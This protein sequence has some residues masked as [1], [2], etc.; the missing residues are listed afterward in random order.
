[1]KLKFTSLLV[2]AGLGACAFNSYADDLLQIYQ[3]AQQ[4][5]PVILQA[6]AERDAA[7]ERINQSQA[8]LLPQVSLSG[9]YTYSS[10]LGSYTPAKY[11]DASAGLTLTQSIFSRA[12][13]LNLGISEKNATQQEALYG[14]QQQDLMVRV[15]TA[16]FNVLRAIDDLSYVRANKTAVKRQL[17][18][19]Q[20]RYK[21]GLT[22]I[23]D[24]NEAQAEF[25]RTVAEE[26]QSENTLDNS[27]ESLR[28]LVGV[29]PRDLKLLNTKEF[30][31][32]P[33]THENKFWMDAAIDKNL[34]LNADRIAKQVAEQQIDVAKAGH[35]PTLSLEGGLS[36]QYKHYRND[37]I[38]ENASDEGH[39]DAASVGLQLSMPLYQGGEINSKV[40]EARYDYVAASQSLENT[41][42][43]VQTNLNSTYNNVRANLSSIKA[44]Q[45]TVKSSLSALKATEAG[46]KV[47]TRTIVDVQDATSNYYQAKEELA[48][49]RYDYIINMLTLK[50]LAGTLKESDLQGINNLLFTP[51]E[52]IPVQPAAPSLDN[53]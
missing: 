33:L 21:V 16:Y 3:L 19:T 1:M 20:Q 36:T 11:R 27:Y 50:Q 25:D 52:Q 43:T 40:R 28:K 24:V 13:W 46:F 4:K 38:A 2:A 45:Q 8:S 44:Y 17:D 6:K 39:G 10:T 26:I 12:N 15:A 23:T 29:M 53:K 14:Y 7:F 9:G 47:G 51:K 41:Y 22:P 31:P 34:Q 5:D 35:L 49:S 42:R 18:Q 48:G 32:S 37:Y 30:S